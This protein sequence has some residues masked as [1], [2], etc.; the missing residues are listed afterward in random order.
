MCWA[1]QRSWRLVPTVG[2]AAFDEGDVAPA[3]VGTSPWLGSFRATSGRREPQRRW[4]LTSERVD[5]LLTVQMRPDV[6][7]LLQHDVGL[8]MT[9]PPWLG[10]GRPI[11]TIVPFAG[12]SRTPRHDRRSPAGHVQPRLDEPA[13]A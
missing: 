11:V 13:S 10:Q 1:D 3:G 6:D 5:H 9:R 2:A 8:G 4:A 7:R 12:I